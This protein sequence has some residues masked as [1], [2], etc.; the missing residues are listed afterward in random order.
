[1]EDLASVVVDQLRAADGPS[2]HWL[3]CCVDDGNHRKTRYAAIVPETKD[4]KTCYAVEILN[5]ELIYQ[6]YEPDSRH[7]FATAVNAATFFC[8]HVEGVRQDLY[9]NDKPY[10]S[11][12]LAVVDSEQTTKLVDEA[13]PQNERCEI[14][15]LVNPTL[16]GNS[17][18]PNQIARIVDAV[19]KQI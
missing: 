1:M 8:A 4:G 15:A 17:C 7:V 11:L 3:L 12:K 19:E 5:R 10:A 16:R 9:Q 14:T 18:F 6:K 13:L 2:K